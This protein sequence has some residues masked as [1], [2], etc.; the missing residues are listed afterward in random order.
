MGSG[1]EKIKGST[2]ASSGKNVLRALVV[3][4]SKFHRVLQTAL[5]RFFKVETTAAENGKEAVDL[6][7][8]GATRTLRSMG[9]DA[10]IVG[11]TA[12][13]SSE[14]KEEF[15][16]AGIDDFLLKPLTADNIASLLENMGKN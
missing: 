1:P 5:L 3:D 6:F 12:N 13:A 2:S 10:K 11:I 9:V 7:R 8:S 16:E 14:S 15:M 4:D